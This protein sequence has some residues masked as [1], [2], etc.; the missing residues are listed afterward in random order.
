MDLLL[1]IV[2]SL[3]SFLLILVLMGVAFFRQ[4]GSLDLSKISAYECGFQPFD[5]L[6][7]SFTVGYFLIGLSFVI[8]DVEV[9]FRLPLVISLLFQLTI[10]NWVVLRRM[11]FV[12]FAGWL[13]EWYVGAFEFDI[14]GKTRFN[15]FFVTK[16][17]IIIFSLG[18]NIGGKV[19]VLW[20]T[21]FIFRKAV[22]S[23]LH[24][25][26]LFNLHAYRDEWQRKQTIRIK[27]G[28]AAQVWEYDADLLADGFITLVE[29]KEGGVEEE[30]GKE[31][32]AH[33]DSFVVKAYLNVDWAVLKETNY[34]FYA[35]VIKRHIEAEINQSTFVDQGGQTP[36]GL[37]LSEYC[38]VESLTFINR[39][40]PWRHYRIVTF[41]YRM[42]CTRVSIII[43]WQ[44]W[45]L[46]KITQL[47]LDS[48][49]IIVKKL[50]WVAY[51][52][53]VWCF[54]NL[55]W[56]SGGYFLFIVFV[57]RPLLLSLGHRCLAKTFGFGTER[58]DVVVYERNR[59]EALEA[60]KLFEAG[61]F[62]YREQGKGLIDTDT[63]D[64]E[65][66]LLEIAS[67]SVLRV[68]PRFFTIGLLFLVVSFCLVVYAA[69]VHDKC[70]LQVGLTLTVFGY[71]FIVTASLVNCYLAWPTA[72]S[73]RWSLWK[74]IK[75]FL[76]LLV[77]IWGWFL[78]IQIIVGG[79]F[80]LSLLESFH[81]F[82]HTQHFVGRFGSQEFDAVDS[83]SRLYGAEDV[84]RVSHYNPDKLTLIKS[85]PYYYKASSHKVG[86][87]YNKYLVNQ[88]P[89]I[90]RKFNIFFQTTR[91]DAWGQFAAKTKFSKFITKTPKVYIHKWWVV[92]GTS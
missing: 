46:E 72:D 70:Y 36:Y 75:W 13:Y 1:I 76:S 8:F 83:L 88:Y 61:D 34:D 14:I 21:Q 80:S 50:G 77:S 38:F 11:L 43:V 53:V 52:N 69:Y 7:N 84:G 57:M 79:V 12:L 45:G 15:N 3:L 68:F 20:R 67:G 58:L 82:D 64:G 33:F 71:W 74:K 10:V 9:V 81:I 35:G 56:N 24:N 55:M 40:V 6:G 30:V 31:L 60:Y 16:I 47:T 39:L 28:E 27:L 48:F 73:V 22:V 26:K 85:S 37:Y 90:E 25:G 59:L 44:L 92:S 5:S 54:E 2:F 17:R 49:I 19:G 91:K 29:T 42:F 23:V 66:G 62:K 4:R 87:F 78:I 51:G 63:F 18:A 32:W 41:M 86:R 65:L 89:K